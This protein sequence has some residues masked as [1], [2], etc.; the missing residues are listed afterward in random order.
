MTTKE[1]ESNLEEKLTGKGLKESKS[2]I[3]AKIKALM[4]EKMQLEINSWE[5]SKKVKELD[6]SKLQYKIKDGKLLSAEA[7]SSNA[8]YTLYNAKTK[9]ATLTSG[10]FIDS[11]FALDDAER[12]DFVLGNKG[13]T[14]TIGNYRFSFEY[15]EKVG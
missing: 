14:H 15:L 13:K 9:V 7:L 5:D 8:L 1:K 6:F 2:E 10:M 4:D 11:I 3:D 12:I